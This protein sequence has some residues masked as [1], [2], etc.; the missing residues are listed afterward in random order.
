[1]TTGLNTFMNYLVLT[2]D[3]VGST[4]LQRLITM[5]LYLEN[6]DVV[7]THEL[8]N[9]LKLENKVATKDPQLGY[10]Q[11]LVEIAN[12]LKGSQIQT[13]LVSRLAK[14]H[15]DNRKDPTDDCQDFYRFLHQ[16][17]EKKIMCV[18]ENI[19][20]YAM[21][22]SIRE[23]SGVLNVYDKE[24]RIKVEQV[25]EVDENYFIQ[26]CKHY[27]KYIEWIENNFPEVDTVSYENMVKNSDEVMEK[28]TGFRKTFT[29]KV[30]LPLSSILS[31][32]Y[33]FL[34]NKSESGLF[35]NEAKA[36]IRYRMV[37]NEMLDKNIVLGAPLKNTTLTDKK[38]QITNFNSCLDK[39]Y[40]FAKNHNW[41]DQS[42][43]TYDFWN[44]E[45]IC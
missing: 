4:I 15:L 39:F 14:Y 25:S 6:C 11:N 41:I 43:A 16:H 34:R 44:E 12:I 27:V 22:W 40:Q 10:S 28:L 38:K 45:Q 2:P 8:T 5:T 20:E 26:K 24:D 36:L 19:F 37:F 31:K 3:G 33:N 7:N 17:F 13:S 18:R 42:K 9:G 21:S 1:M 30:G 35:H 32:E 23:R 29:D